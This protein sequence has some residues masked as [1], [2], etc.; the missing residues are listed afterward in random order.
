MF[1][2]VLSCVQAQVLYS[3]QISLSLIS[4]RKHSI[5]HSIPCWA[6][7]SS[8]SVGYKSGQCQCTVSGKAIFLCLVLSKTLLTLKSFSPYEL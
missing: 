3:F 4:E 8:Q 7:R 6:S 2:I 5:A 1:L